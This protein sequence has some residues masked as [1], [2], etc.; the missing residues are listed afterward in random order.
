MKGRMFLFLIFWL[1]VFGRGYSQITTFNY[2][3]S[4][5]PTGSC[6]SFSPAVDVLGSDGIEYLHTSME[7]API[8]ASGAI[9]LTAYYVG[10]GYNEHVATAYAISYPFKTGYTYS[11]SIS[12]SNQLIANT[13]AFNDGT[14]TTGSTTNFVVGVSNTIPYTSSLNGC[15]SE[16]GGTYNAP[17]SSIYSAALTTGSSVLTI[18]NVT[19]LSNSAYLLI[20]GWVGTISSGTNYI[21]SYSNISSITITAT[22]DITPSVNY[23]CASQVYSVPGSLPATWTVAPAGVVSLAPNGNSVTVTK[24]TEGNVTLTA[25]MPGGIVATIPISTEPTSTVTSTPS[26]SCDGSYQD[27][28]V[29]ASANAP[30]AGDWQWTVTYSSGYYYISNPSGSST[31]VDVTGGV[32][33]NVYY[34]DA[35]GVTS[36]QNGTTVYSSCGTGAVAFTVFPNPASGSATVT[37][38]TPTVTAAPET[39]SGGTTGSGKAQPAAAPAPKI[40][41]IRITDKTGMLRKSQQYVSGFSSTQVSLAGLEPGIYFISAFDGKKWTTQKLV[42]Q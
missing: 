35:C 2:A 1:L 42:V 24:L 23:I 8:F 18:P 28:Y 27:W 21:A 34:K 10:S 40:Y 4:G 41:G 6:N 33:L 32:G 36:V 14:P 29:S 7:A 3:T 20:G 13:D 19:V 26:G 17:F 22:P 11:I 38:V 5:L 31:Y 12:L 9:D 37:A 16:L 39:L 30:G 25:T 15:T